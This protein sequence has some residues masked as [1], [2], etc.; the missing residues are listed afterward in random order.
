MQRD[1]QTKGRLHL[2]DSRAGRDHLFRFRGGELDLSGRTH[3]AGVLNVTPDSFSDGGKFFERDAALAHAERMIE[4]GADILDVGGEST[5]PYSQPVDASEEAARVVPVISLLSKRSDVIISVDT[6]KA[7]VARAAL[8]AGAHI[9]NDVSALRFDPELAGIAA[10]Y[11]AGL[12]L[13]HMKGTP[14]T[15]QESPEYG[16]V[17]Y[18]ITR[19]LDDAIQRARKDGVDF[20]SIIIDP[21]IGFGKKL[22]HNLTILKRLS[23]FRALK[24]PIMVGPSRKSFIGTLLDRPVHERTSGTLAAVVASVMSG[25]AVVRVHDV[26]QAKEAVVIADAILSN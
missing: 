10:E 16:D 7:A 22:E 8:D 24:R 1:S 2:A 4:E 9:I 18:E 17:V 3:V 14:R 5:R 11:G 13:M 21:G 25:A 23:E 6:S 19:F 20:E 15:M 26:R 12:V